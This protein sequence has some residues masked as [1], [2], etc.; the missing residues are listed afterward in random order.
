MHTD[1]TK[2]KIAEQFLNGLR[3]RDWDS[4]RAII[5][6]DIAWSVP[7]RSLISGEAHGADAIIERAQLIASYRLTFTL[8]HI[9][10]GQYDV[11]LSL[12]NTARRGDLILDHH[13]A[14]IL[15]LRDGMICAINT[16]LSDVALVNAFFI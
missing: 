15:L 16:Y 3:T 5:T 6:D 13:L 12:N 11:A 4:M 7:G 1:A 9:L 14:V 8:K 10:L 2:E